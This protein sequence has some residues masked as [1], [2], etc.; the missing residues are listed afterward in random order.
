MDVKY[1][2]SNKV[3]S[4]CAL[5]QNKLCVGT[6]TGEVLVFDIQR[7]RVEYEIQSLRPQLTVQHAKFFEEPLL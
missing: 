3:S 4:A 1:P 5:S 2:F 7:N 6:L